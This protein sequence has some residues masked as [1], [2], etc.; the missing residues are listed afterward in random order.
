MSTD[1]GAAKVYELLDSLNIDYQKHTHPPV[2]TIEEAAPYWKDI[3]GAHCKNLFLRDAKGKRHFLVVLPG[4]KSAD[5]KRLAAVIGSTR[6][7]FASPRRLERY[8]GLEPGSVSV[9]GIVN[10]EENH[11]RV[12]IDREILDEEFV[13]FHPNINTVTLTIPTAGLRK[14]L[15]SQG[16]EIGFIGIDGADA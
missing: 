13:N 12:Y 8:L 9:L 1:K 15:E 2:N 14:F 10:D 11:V 6:L 3:P 16:N 4:H 5:L 7:S